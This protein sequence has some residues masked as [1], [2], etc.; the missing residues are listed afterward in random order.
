MNNQNRESKLDATRDER[1][2]IEAARQQI[3]HSES[4]DTP[5]KPWRN[6]STLNSPV[7]VYAAGT[8]IGVYKL[9]EKL[10]EGGFGVV[11][12]AEQ[13]EPIRRKV[14][15]KIIKP[16]MDTKEVISRFEAERQALTLMDHPNIAKV[17][18]A[19]A[20]ETGHPYFVMELVRGIPITD[21]CDDHKL[22]V[23]Q[24]LKLFIKV[25]QAV[26]HAHQKGIIHRDIKPR[27]ILV[28]LQDN[29][30]TPKVIDFGVAKATSQQ[31]TEHTVHTL[32]AQLIGTPLYMSPEQVDQSRIDI[33]TRTDVYSLGVLLYEMLT[34]T[35][36]IDRKRLRKANA[37][38]LIEIICHEET[39]KPSARI[40]VSSDLAGVIASS[41][42]TEPLNL[43]QE[44]RGD[45]DWI[46]MRALE[47]DRTRRFQTATDFSNDVQRF[48]NDEP[49]SASPPSTVYRIRKFARRNKV[50]FTAG[51]I[52]FC[53]LIIA[54]AV[55]S[56][57]AILAI[58]S[59]QRAQESHVAELESRNKLDAAQKQSLAAEIEKTQMLEASREQVDKAFEK[60]LQI[61]NEAMVQ[62]GISGLSDMPRMQ[63]LR[64]EILE[65]ATVRFEGIISDI[66]WEG[67]RHYEL[68]LNY[69]GLLESLA[70]IRQWVG[71]D[72]DAL[73]AFEK[74]DQTL[75]SL[76]EKYT[77]HRS[78]ILMGRVSLK[79]GQGMTLRQIGQASKAEKVLR[80]SIGLARQATVEFPVKANLGLCRALN[81]LGY[82]LAPTSRWTEAEPF[83]REAVDIGSNLSQQ[84]PDDLQVSKES[85][86][87]M[88]NFANYLRHTRRP[89][90]SDANFNQALTMYR[91]LSQRDDADSDV[92]SSLADSASDYAILLDQ[93]NKPEKAIGLR[94]EALEVSRVIAADYPYVPRFQWGL[95]IRLGNIA[96]AEVQGG[97]Y[98][99][100]QEKYK[101]STEI[102]RDL[103][104]QFP[105]NS[106]FRGTL[107][108]NLS[109]HGRNYQKLE[110]YHTAQDFFEESGKHWKTLSENH[111]DNPMY[112]VR[113]GEALT[114]QARCLM[115]RR[116]GLQ[117][118][119]ELT[120]EAL[121]HFDL[122]KGQGPVSAQTAW[123]DAIV[124]QLKSEIL[125]FH[126]GHEE[127]AIET[128]AKVVQHVDLAMLD[129]VTAY[130]R[131]CYLLVWS[132]NESLRNPKKAIELAD[133][134]FSETPDA[135][136]HRVL[137]IAYFR[138]GDFEKSLNSM[139]T[140]RE[141]EREPN[142]NGVDIIY[143]R[144]FM[145]MTLQ[146]LARNEEAR[147]TY[148]E[149]LEL[150][151]DFDFDSLPQHSAHQLKALADETANLLSKDN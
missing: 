118:G 77:H 141:L 83:Y 27:N 102:L 29:S 11:Y 129:Q 52:A 113:L 21:F 97:Q 63:H 130:R 126:L 19:G 18:D 46:V 34:G 73:V 71:A 60:S 48:L 94:Q 82:L 67:E 44:L 59:G 24:R 110:D 93:E 53:S 86:R 12:V 64:R 14:A 140:S 74:A 149:A 104:I 151:N 95:A 108:N 36:P 15:L 28:G 20:T 136:S 51:S 100:A 56:V 55:S 99:S 69:A 32:G 62:V 114:G 7:L 22:G 8:Q 49:V 138:N 121:H 79:Y 137:G 117:R 54:T 42:G 41:R 16:G 30:S 116:K 35:T 85:A 38:E 142:G 50:A 119:L 72:E 134:F 57:M 4:G 2:L 17:F 147:N 139:T 89:A 58:R 3:L 70:R 81:Q 37:A 6:D 112:H 65:N 150:L 76:E 88:H 146:K 39:I 101:E 109:N 144:L 26:Q 131:Y 31:L 127:E 84:C 111:A 91:S 43:R 133:R 145:A 128:M 132:Q 125:G 96:W 13:K 1:E 40:D 123:R 75:V 106:E 61:L 122:A 45:L 87:A 23:R 33:D 143:T 25:C 47:K 9:L 68:M 105:D 98:E 5:K 124:L 92:R 103:V 107:A 120:D 115:S 10:G 90:E 80:Q 78:E 135:A 148:N 66:D